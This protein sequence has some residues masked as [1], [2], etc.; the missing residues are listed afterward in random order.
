MSKYICGKNSVKEALKNKVPI[1]KIYFSNK[2][3]INLD[4][5]IEL[6]KI[7][8]HQLDK[9]ASKTNHQ[10][11]I[12]EIEKFNYFNIKDI[13]EDKPQK[14]LILDHIQ[15]P[16]NF[17]AIIRT[18][19]ALGI[20][21]IIIPKKRSIKVTPIVLKVS[22]GGQIGIKIIRVD[23]LNSIVDKLKNNNF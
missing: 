19:N 3:N 9:I 22:S 10:G 20:K 16:Y 13:F 14:I 2:L 8:K 23:S 4:S 1:K 18:S 6:K 12:A 7:S 21:H 5:N 11:I 17:G 15:D